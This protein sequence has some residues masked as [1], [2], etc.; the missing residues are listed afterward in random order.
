MKPLKRILIVNPFGIGDC[1]FLT[2]LIRALKKEAR[3]EKI[4]LLLGSRTE[5][6]FENDS[7]VDESIP[8]DRGWFRKQSFLR[9]LKFVFS[10]IL[11][12]RKEKFDTLIDVSLSREYSFLAKFFLGIHKRIGFDYHKRGLF[13]SDRFQLPQGYSNKHV[14]KYYLDLLKPLE[15]EASSQ[16]MH[17]HVLER[18]INEVDVLRESAFNSGDDSYIVVAPGGGDSWGRDAQ[19]KR[20]PVN[21]FVQLLSLLKMDLPTKQIVLLGSPGEKDLAEDFLELGPEFSVV[22]W[23][24]K[25]KLR[26]SFALIKKAAFVLTNDGGI[27]HVSKALKTPVIAFYGP[28]DPMVYGPF[29]KTLDDVTIHRKDLECQP[30]YSSF[31][32]NSECQTIDCLRGLMPNNVA[33][34]I[35]KSDLLEKAKIKLNTKKRK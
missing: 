30:C 11:R 26:E 7:Y 15:V 33:E 6:V 14:I 1:L 23:I 8:I 12:L 2:P 34:E 17:L 4:V 27:C 13:L 32:Y 35:R 21:Y 31:R 9:K 10:L 24:G 16:E 5:A 19:F 28:V 22:N 29:P 20:W 25:R 3:V 18:E